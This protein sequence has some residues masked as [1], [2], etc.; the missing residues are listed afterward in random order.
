M[1]SQT[2][3]AQVQAKCQK[4][5]ESERGVRMWQLILEISPSETILCVSPRRKKTKKQKRHLT[6]FATLS[7]RTLLLFTSTHYLFLSFF[8]LIREIE[9]FL[10]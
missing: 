3:Q 1:F 9:S 2:S 6:I 4:V 8:F 10:F 5:H 7:P